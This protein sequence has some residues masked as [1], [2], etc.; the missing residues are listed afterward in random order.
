MLLQDG[1]K[2]NAR[3][4]IRENSLSQRRKKCTQTI[5]RGLGVMVFILLT[6]DAVQQ[7]EVGKNLRWKMIAYEL[8][9]FI[10]SWMPL[11]NRIYSLPIWLDSDVA[12]RVV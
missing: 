3:M 11:I 6:L 8:E 4:L 9:H 12:W 5:Q 2:I 7:L 1:A 10:V